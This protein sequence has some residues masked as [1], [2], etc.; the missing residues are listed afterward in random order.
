M[1]TVATHARQRNVG[2]AAAPGRR[3]GYAARTRLVP[4]LMLIRR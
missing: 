1:A 3:R 2:P 4:Y